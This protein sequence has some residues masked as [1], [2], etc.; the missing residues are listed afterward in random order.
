MIM[1]SWIWDAI[2]AIHVR[3]KECNFSPKIIQVRTKPDL[4][5]FFDEQDVDSCFSIS[6]QPTQLLNSEMVFSDLFAVDASALTSISDHDKMALE[7]YL[8]YALLPYYAKKHR[9]CYAISHFA[10]TLDGRIATSSGDSKWIGNQENLE[11][12]HRM[13]A[14]CDGIIVGS[15]TVIVDNPNL[16]VR[17]VRGNDPRRIVIGGADLKSDSYK[18]FDKNTLVFTR[19]LNE[20]E[21]R[22]NEKKTGVYNTNHILA[23]LFKSGMNSVYIEGGS[24]TTSGFLSQ[25]TLD[26]VQLHISPQLL[27]SGIS[28]FCFDGAFTIKDSVRFSTHKFIPMG[29]DVMFLGTI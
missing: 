26:Q 27:G 29:S 6:F 9:K 22:S 7:L 14:L 28:T 24:V 16:N 2:C 12:S 4:Q 13:R 1:S 17:H 3:L 18:V 21:D 19:E 8:P 10:Q 5:V 25:G 20:K 15:K 23:E 11:H